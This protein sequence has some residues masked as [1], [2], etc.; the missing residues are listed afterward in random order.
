LWIA[1]E[2]GSV[3]FVLYLIANVYILRMGLSALRRRA[4]RERRAAA[5]CYLALA[6]AYWIPGLTL[7]SGVYSELNLYLFFLLGL[8]ARTFS[9][10]GDSPGIE[11]AQSH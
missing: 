6:A 7:S 8:L 10:G 11:R 1:A 2:L 9:S 4:G 5:A 3:A